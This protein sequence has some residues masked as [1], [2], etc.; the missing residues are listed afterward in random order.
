MYNYREKNIVVH[1]M[2][3]RENILK[4]KHNTNLHLTF[5][6]ATAYHS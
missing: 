5:L 4:K 1:S 3:L 2:L 6:Y